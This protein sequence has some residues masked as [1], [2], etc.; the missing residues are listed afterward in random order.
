VLRGLAGSNGATSARAD[1]ED[2]APTAPPAST[3]GA[4]LL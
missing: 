4:C 3:G 1:E 2:F